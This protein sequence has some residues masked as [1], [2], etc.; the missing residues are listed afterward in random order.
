MKE[1][2][3]KNKV[4]LDPKKLE[5]AVKIQSWWKIILFR[6]KKL[7]LLQAF[8]RGYLARKAIT[9]LISYANIL[10]LRLTHLMKSSSV[11][12]LKRVFNH[13]YDN[14]AVEAQANDFL[15]IVI[16]LQKKVR[17]YLGAK[18]EKTAK[19]RRIISRI[20]EVFNKRI[21]DPYK[22]IRVSK[23]GILKRQKRYFKYNKGFEVVHK[24]LLRKKLNRL[25]SHVRL[26]TI[27][28]KRLLS[29]SEG[30]LRTFLT[31]WHKSL[32][33]TENHNN[34]NDVNNSLFSSSKN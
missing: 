29:I 25:I 34:K 1:L 5:A 19:V 2:A 20:Q 8:I 17:Q 23:I 14:F 32:I 26:N 16:F 21:K 12:H 27:V 33:L 7:I 28:N 31:K 24:Y 18:F 9:E 13:L 10:N 6:N 22:L 15:N 4:N 3:M 30:N 11:P